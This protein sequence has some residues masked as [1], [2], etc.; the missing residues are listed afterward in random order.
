MY[1]NQALSREVRE[2]YFFLKKQ[3]CKSPKNILKFIIKKKYGS[4]THIFKV[5]LQG[6]PRYPDI[7]DLSE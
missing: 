4:T 6:S 7:H 5:V 2:T 1:S 3:K